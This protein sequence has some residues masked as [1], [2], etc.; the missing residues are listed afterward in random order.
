MARARVYTPPVTVEGKQVP[1]ETV[2]SPQPTTLSFPQDLSPY[3]VDVTAQQPY[4]DPIKSAITQ[5]LF[6]L[7]L[8]EFQPPA[9]APYSPSY[10]SLGEPP[11][12]GLMPPPD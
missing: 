6:G 11:V 2:P 3:S 12:P 1:V 5:A 9:S 7:A 4:V 8:K 10:P